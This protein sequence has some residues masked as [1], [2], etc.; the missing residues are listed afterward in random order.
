MNAHKLFNDVRE[1]NLGKKIVTENTTTYIY[2][3]DGNSGTRDD[4]TKKD[5]GHTQER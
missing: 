5:A 3:H 1:V 4:G 2:T